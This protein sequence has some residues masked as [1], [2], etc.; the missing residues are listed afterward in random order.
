MKKIII[1]FLLFLLLTLFIFA[2]LFIVFRDTKRATPIAIIDG[3]QFSISIAKSD[4]E[5]TLGL[6][7]KKSLPVNE[8]MLFPFAKAGDYAFWM[9]DMRFS[10]D[11]IFIANHHIVTIFSHVPYPQNAT[12]HLPEYK[13]TSPADTVLEINA[14]LSQKYMFREGDSV[15][16]QL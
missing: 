5:K 7:N 14:G 11:I 6:S 4:S 8:G 1:F 16:I 9:K 2:L 13:P 3:H 15:I 12:T 10:I